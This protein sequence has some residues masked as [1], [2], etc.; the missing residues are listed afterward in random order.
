MNRTE[1]EREMAAMLGWM[2]LHIVE[3]EEDGHCTIMAKNPTNGQLMRY[4]P[5]TGYFV[6]ARFA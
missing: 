1:A 3:N 5:S 6:D 2:D 4:E